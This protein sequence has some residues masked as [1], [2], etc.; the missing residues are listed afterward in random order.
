MRRAADLLRAQ[1]HG[2]RAWQ[3]APVWESARALWDG[4]RTATGDDAYE[5]YCEHQRLRHPCEPLMSRREFSA[6]ATG[7]KWGGVSRCC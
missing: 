3:W 1:W 4:L 6:E 5:R 7:R 2:R